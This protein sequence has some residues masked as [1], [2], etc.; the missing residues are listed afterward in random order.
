MKTGQTNGKGSEEKFRSFYIS[1]DNQFV[2]VRFRKR[3]SRN[4]NIRLKME[5]IRR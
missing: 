4:E 3:N 1:N 5:H 2:Y